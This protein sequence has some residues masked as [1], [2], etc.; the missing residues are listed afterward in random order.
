MQYFSNIA[1]Q[2]YAYIPSLYFSIPLRLW[3][4]QSLVFRTCLLYRQYNYEKW[5]KEKIIPNLPPNYEI[6]DNASY[7]NFLQEQRFTNLWSTDYQR[8]GKNSMFPSY[9]F[10]VKIFYLCRYK[11]IIFMAKSLYYIHFKVHGFVTID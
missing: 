2:K 5:E 4:L 3:H 8:S 6:V 11:H 10:M 7:Y 9:I 1:Q